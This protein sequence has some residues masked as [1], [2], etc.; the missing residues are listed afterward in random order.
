M[1]NI[2]L[3]LMVAVAFLG[4]SLYQAWQRDYAPKPQQQAAAP[5]GN[6]ATAGGGDEPSVNMGAV[7]DVSVPA[8]SASTTP[9]VGAVQAASSRKIS[10]ET[11]LFRILIDT[12]GGTLTD[13]W[14]E[15]YPVSIEQPDVKL[16]L[17]TPAPP[18]LFIAQSGLKS[19]KGVEAP[20]HEAEYRAESFDYKLADGQNELVVDLVWRGAN[21][22]TVTK[23]YR[24]QR[25]S[26]AITV[27][28]IVENKG[29]QPW[30]ARGYEQ[31]QRMHEGKT[32]NVFAARAYVGA[33]IYSPDEK[34]EKIHFNKMAETPLNRDVTGGWVAMM[35]HYFISA[36]IPPADEPEH[37]YSMALPGGRYVVG[38]YSPVVSVA[39]GESHTFGSRLVVGP[40]LQDKLAKMAPGLEL[41]A[42]YGW[43]T[44]L[45]K[46][47]FWLLKWFHNLFGNWGWAIIFLTITIKALFYKLS[48]ASYRSMANMRKLAPRLKALK[49]RYG[50]DKAR[51]NQAMMEMYKKEKINPLGGCLPMVVQIPFFISLYWVL[52][53]AVELRQAPFMLWIKDLS[54]AD[55]YF[56]LPVLMGVTMLAQQKL[57]PA[58]MDPMQQKVMMALPVVFTVFFAFFP[59]G[60]VLYW[61]T[62]NLL[63]IAQQYVIT[64]RIEASAN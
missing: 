62:N 5:S 17:L 44:I 22:V 60:L 27:E 8:A 33:A 36:W 29:D 64:K 53:E 7:P 58:P 56:V 34:Y 16:K 21:G 52:M 42:D 47:M 2:R 15:Q 57:N 51:M 32:R 19:G 4:F 50:D 26:Y 24:F 48:E 55:P 25:D 10:V 31:L 1:D 63:S 20:T 49:E 61:F 54:I 23:R 11:D 39:P 59:A 45:A 18:E 6:A 46:P 9:V 40:K 35:Q 14:L 3:L 28:H 12:R 41:T 43:L 37:F 13:A 30:S 38:A